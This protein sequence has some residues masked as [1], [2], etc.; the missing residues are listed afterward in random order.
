V[1]K[2]EKRLQKYNSLL[3]MM[4]RYSESVFRMSGLL[5]RQSET[6]FRINEMK[7]PPPEII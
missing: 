4:F 1:R 2:I 6:I 5:L 7:F 3:E